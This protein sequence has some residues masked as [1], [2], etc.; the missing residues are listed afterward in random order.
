MK[1]GEEGRSKSLITHPQQRAAGLCL[2][3]GEHCAGS[4][5]TLACRGWHCHE[6][7]HRKSQRSI[8]HFPTC[9]PHWDEWSAHFP[10][11]SNE[12]PSICPS[13]GIQRSSGGAAMRGTPVLCCVVLFLQILL[14]G[15]ANIQAL[16]D[17]FFNRPVLSAWYESAAVTFQGYCLCSICTNRR[18]RNVTVHMGC[19]HGKLSIWGCFTWRKKRRDHFPCEEP[20]SH[21]EKSYRLAAGVAIPSFQVWHREEVLQCTH[22]KSAL[23]GRDVGMAPMLQPC[24][25]GP[26]FGVRIGSSGH[27]VPKGTGLGCPHPTAQHSAA[28]SVLL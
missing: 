22:L 24:R 26:H 3:G 10:K 5:V 2:A 17:S 9:T 11:V 7:Q 8:Q 16:S 21:R 6:G 18:M 27:V 19:A 20:G 1:Q 14:S 12:I 28:I 23:K 15:F 4:G 25:Q 13:R